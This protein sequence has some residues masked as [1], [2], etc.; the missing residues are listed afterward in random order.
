V[1][2]EVARA[3]GWIGAEAGG[4]VPALMETLRNDSDAAVRERA[5]WAIGQIGR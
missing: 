2:H 3:L 4:A 5:A 1:R